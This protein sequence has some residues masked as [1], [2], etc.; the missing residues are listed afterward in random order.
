MQLSKLNLS[1]REFN[2]FLEFKRPMSI[3]TIASLLECS[4]NYAYQKIIV[5]EARGMLKKIQIPHQKKSL[6]ISNPKFFEETAETE[7]KQ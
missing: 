5:W 1:E 2:L 4:Y 3:A 6:Y 7:D